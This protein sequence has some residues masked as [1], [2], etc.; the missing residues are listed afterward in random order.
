MPPVQ[1]SLG[2]VAIACFADRPLS[3]CLSR[4]SL[5]VNQSPGA[6]QDKQGKQHQSEWHSHDVKAASGCVVLAAAGG[7]AG[8]R[9]LTS[10][11]SLSSA[12]HPGCPVWVPEKAQGPDGNLKAARWLKGKV[13]S[14]V[15]GPDGNGLLEVSLSYSKI[16][17]LLPPRKTMGPQLAAVNPSKQTGT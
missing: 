4:G 15:R 8:I 10:R 6:Q 11:A 14:L 12:Y 13:V 1:C 17:D 2:A 5:A 3:S 7:M 9:K 16:K